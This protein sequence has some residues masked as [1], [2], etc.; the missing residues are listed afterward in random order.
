LSFTNGYTRGSPIATAIAG[1]SYFVAC[2][3]V[4]QANNA[5]FNN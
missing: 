1:Q 3:A 2:L 4:G 5:N